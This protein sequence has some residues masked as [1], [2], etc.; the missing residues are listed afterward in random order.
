MILNL[1]TKIEITSHEIKIW[2]FKKFIQ[3]KISEIET[4]YY[5]KGLSIKLKN[6]YIK[7]PEYTNLNEYDLF[8]E[9]KEMGINGSEHSSD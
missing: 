7:I 3:F 4:I 9:L 1:F 8:Y 2:R 5:D 6:Q